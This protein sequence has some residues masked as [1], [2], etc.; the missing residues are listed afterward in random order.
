MLSTCCSSHCTQCQGFCRREPALWE[1]IGNCCLGGCG[2]ILLEKL[3]AAVCVELCML[4]CF[5]HAEEIHSENRILVGG[6][7]VL[8]KVI[9]GLW[10]R[11]S[12]FMLYIRFSIL[13]FQTFIYLRVYS[14]QIVAIVRPKAK[15]WSLEV[16]WGLTWISGAQARG[17]SSTV[18]QGTLS[19]SWIGSGAGRTQTRAHMGCQYLHLVCCDVG[20]SWHVFQ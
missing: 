15:Y 13:S 14:P 8:L 3:V 20:S 7:L 16:L 19:G 1:L 9:S 12:L 11:G 4:N 17:S 5:S 6:T 18:F 10:T 2:V